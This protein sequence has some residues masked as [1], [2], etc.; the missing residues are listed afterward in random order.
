MISMFAKVDFKTLSIIISI[1]NEERTIKTVLEK[2]IGVQLPRDIQKQVIVINDG[3]SDNSKTIIEEFIFSG[4]HQNI[5]FI[6]SEINEG[7]GFN[8]QRNSKGNR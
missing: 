8:P 2:V 4:Q 1:Y 7:R 6:N 3:S 5:D